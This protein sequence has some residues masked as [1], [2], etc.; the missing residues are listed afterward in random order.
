MFCFLG[1]ILWVGT[2]SPVSFTFQ[3][4]P[5]GPLA[6]Q[7]RGSF[8]SHLVSLPHTSGGLQFEPERF[9]FPRWQNQMV[10]QHQST[11][12]LTSS[13]PAMIGSNKYLDWNI[14]FHAVPLSI[15][16][17]SAQLPHTANTVQLIQ[18]CINIALVPQTDTPIQ[19][20]RVRELA[21]SLK[22]KAETEG[23]QA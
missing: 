13:I 1:L 18:Y 14:P 20:L 22:M 9:L 6:R 10:S 4:A 7:E 19:K 17:Y 11:S 21:Y 23:V 2:E 12:L 5:Y 15:I 3:N 8:T 16:A